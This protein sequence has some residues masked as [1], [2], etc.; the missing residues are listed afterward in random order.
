MLFL[1]IS[2][3]RANAYIRVGDRL[4]GAW[5]VSAIRHLAG[6]SSSSNFS[7]TFDRIDPRVVACTADY[8]GRARRFRLVFAQSAVFALYDDATGARIA[9]FE[10]FSSLHP[11]LTATGAF[12]GDSVYSAAF[13]SQNTLQLS[14]FNLT[15]K[16]AAH[17]VFSKAAAPLRAF[18]RRLP[19]LLSAALIAGKAVA[20]EIRRARAAR[21]EKQRADEENERYADP[22][23]LRK[24]ERSE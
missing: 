4:I 13:V 9:D 22:N 11:H 3:C 20:R 16:A 14:V 1:L 15:T 2:A 8:G 10:F 7:A 18:E 23:E 17:F 21:R 19:L 5:R 12:G 6:A 24:L